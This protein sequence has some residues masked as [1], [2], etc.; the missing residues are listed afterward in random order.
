MSILITGGTGSFG[1]AFTAYALERGV[2]RVCIFS[3]GEHAQAEMRA[4][5]PNEGRLR[6]FVGD[7]R[8]RDRLRRAMEGVEV[9]IAAAAL[10]RVEVG[11][12]DPLEVVKTNIGGAANIIEAAQDA[13]VKKVVALSTD[14]A[15]SPTNLYG[16]TKLVAEKL[17]LAANNI[18]GDKG[19]RFAVCRYGNIW[20]STGSVVPIWNKMKAEGKTTVPLTDPE[21]T[22]FFM[23]IDEAVEL[24]QKTIETMKG[25]ELVIPDLPAYRLGDLI[26]A[27]GVDAEIIGLP[28]YEKRH[29]SLSA[30]KISD[31]AC[32]MTIKQI[33]EMLCDSAH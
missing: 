5:Y 32:R 3:R 2:E 19:P 11:E 12:Y 13:G 21:C 20:N 6:W 26:E 27:M 7:V 17:F 14:K 16:A 29:E 25:G 23:K 22:R 10:K 33:K 15:E 8:D 1:R 9:V 30:D 4:Q 24:V 28:S 18:T 31:K